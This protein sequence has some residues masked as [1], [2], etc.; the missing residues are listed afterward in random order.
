MKELRA[1]AV[2]LLCASAGPAADWPGWLGPRRDSS[3]EEVVK[4]WQGPLATAWK[5]PVGEGHSSPVVAGGRAYLHTR[6]H[7]KNEEAL[8]AY[9]AATGKQLWQTAYPRAAFNNPFGNGPRATPT[10]A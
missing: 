8:T 9:D 5:Q 2:L 1:F 7:D 10:A 6:V 3:S 4:P